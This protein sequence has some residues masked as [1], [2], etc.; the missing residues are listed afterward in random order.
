MKTGPGMAGTNFQILKI[1][2]GLKT[3]G[4]GCA[5]KPGR[6]TAGLLGN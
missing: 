6:K 5:A 1:H 3:T 2:T 4:L